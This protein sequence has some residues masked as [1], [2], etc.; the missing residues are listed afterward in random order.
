MPLDR[1]PREVAHPATDRGIRPIRRVGIGIV[2]ER[3]IPAVGLNR[4]D[5]VKTVSHVL[6]KSRD[7]R[8]VGQNRS[9]PYN[10]DGSVRSVFHGE[11]PTNSS[12]NA[13]PPGPWPWPCGRTVRLL[14]NLDPK[15]DPIARGE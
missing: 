1:I 5:A 4:R 3:W 9:C 10:C 6:P 11:T 2:V 12:L 15:S 8:G 7:V 14:C 13:T